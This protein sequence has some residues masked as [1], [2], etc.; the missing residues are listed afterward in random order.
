MSSEPVRSN[1]PAR[2]VLITGSRA[3][4]GRAMAL[5]LARPG[6]HL[7]L[8]HRSEAGAPQD[9]LQAV[10]SRGATAEL[11]AAEL[12]D[13]A[14]RDRLMD[15]VAAA[16]PRLHVL[17]NNAGVYPEAG[18]LAISPQQWQAVL[19]ATCSAV[20]H[21]TRRAVPLLEAAAPARVINIGDAAADRI[22]ARTTATPYHVAKLGVH[23]LTRSFARELAGRG[24]TVNML[25]PGF[26]ENSV[27]E[28][29]PMP[30]GR[31]GRFEDLLG[32]LDY[33]LSEEAA[34]VN[35]ANLVVSGG[36]NI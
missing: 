2:V 21:L 35:G 25:S 24:V 14:E 17:V 23:V 6:T 8:H 11:L 9:L 15:A 29:P 34:Y 28:T 10:R 27:G 32:A 33:L 22:Q 3:G 36:W 16:H 5:H 7:L 26:L 1:E 18:L 30:A 12:T 31:P 20:F 4:L 19:D 13:I